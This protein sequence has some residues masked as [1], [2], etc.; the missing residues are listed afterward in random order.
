[1]PAH[2]N[3]VTTLRART[4]KYVNHIRMLCARTSFQLTLLNARVYAGSHAQVQVRNMVDMVERDWAQGRFTYEAQ[5]R[6]RFRSEPA[7]KDLEQKVAA[8]RVCSL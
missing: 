4:E 2:Q 7:G 3:C 8:A 1:M 5:L 6:E